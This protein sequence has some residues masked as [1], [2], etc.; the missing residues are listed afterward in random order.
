MPSLPRTPMSLRAPA[1][2]DDLYRL[3]HDHQIESDRS[4]FA[5][6]QV[7]LQLL[8]RVFDRVPVFVFHLRPAGDARWNH[9]A[10]RVIGDL[11]GQPLHKSRPLRPRSRKCYIA[12]DHV[13]QLRDFVEPRTAQELAHPGEPWVVISRPGRSGVRLRV[14]A[15]GAEFVTVESNPAASHPFLPVQYGPFRIQL[16]GEN[17]ERNYR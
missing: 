4:V 9:L 1:Q 5:V 3:E 6:I 12:S 13:P 11:L 2:Q 8:A 14:L 7:E 15:H 17:D 16:D 10:N